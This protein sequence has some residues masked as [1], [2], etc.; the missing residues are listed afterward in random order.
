MLRGFFGCEI[1]DAADMQACAVEE[2]ECGGERNAFCDEEREKDRGGVACGFGDERQR[3][4]GR[5]YDGEL[6]ENRYDERRAAVPECLKYA[7]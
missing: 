5:K 6:S 2:R 3:V 4:C 7:L 1:K